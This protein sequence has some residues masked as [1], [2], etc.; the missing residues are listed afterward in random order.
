MARE[1]PRVS[2]KGGIIGLAGRAGECHPALST[3]NLAP[4]ERR[5]GFGRVSLKG[6]AKG[7]GERRADADKR[8]KM[9]TGGG[10]REKNVQ[11]K[12]EERPYE[13]REDIEQVLEIPTCFQG[14]LTW[15]SGGPVAE[16]LHR[17]RR[18]RLRM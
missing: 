2:I 13:G 10:E 12:K 11:E 5:E 9:A 8:R 17:R 6:I 15:S 16:K 3:A 14:D 7:E 4:G 1:V 18:W